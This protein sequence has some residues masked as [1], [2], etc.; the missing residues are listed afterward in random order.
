MSSFM[1]FS[2][3][4]TPHKS[5]NV[6]EYSPKDLPPASDPLSSTCQAGIQKTFIQPQLPQSNSSLFGPSALLMPVDA[7]ET[8]Q[9]SQGP[10]RTLSLPERWDLEGYLQL[11]YSLA[12]V[13]LSISSSGLNL[14]DIY[15]PCLIEAFYGTP[16]E[17][18][19]I[20]T[21]NELAICFQKCAGI[22]A[23]FNEWPEQTKASVFSRQVSGKEAL[24]AILQL[25]KLAKGFGIEGESWWE[26]RR[27]LWMAFIEPF[28]HQG[29]ILTESDTFQKI[30]RKCLRVFYNV[31]IKQKPWTYA[32]IAG[33]SEWRKA[34]ETQENVAMD[35]SLLALRRRSIIAGAWGTV[36][37]TV[38]GTQNVV[39]G[40]LLVSSST[41]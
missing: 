38:H 7:S 1:D 24:A 9:D 4:H 36:T 27:N 20:F 31:G 33:L 41:F 6:M 40:S 13:S 39:Q 16:G 34:K 18:G 17:A 10:F 14:W 35:R 19:Y 26:L 22:F 5:G 28:H 11:V 32:I 12:T 15:S 21:E 2:S 37:K 23:T 30:F 29:W 3:P 25:I 8:E